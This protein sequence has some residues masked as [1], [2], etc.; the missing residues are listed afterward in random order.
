M[1]TECI[2]TCPNYN[3]E[4]LQRSVSTHL[5]QSLQS[6]LCLAVVLSHSQNG[7]EDRLT[8]VHRPVKLVV[9][10]PPEPLNKETDKT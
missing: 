6:A 4:A 10:V 2:F 8:R 9:H 1:T 3:I 5:L 7:F